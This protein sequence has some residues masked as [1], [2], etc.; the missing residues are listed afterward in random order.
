[1]YLV[2]ILL[3]HYR[4]DVWPL[5]HVAPSFAP[6]RGMQTQQVLDPRETNGIR[7]ETNTQ[8]LELQYG[9]GF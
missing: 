1:T 9:T 6:G 3:K 2:E 8:I 7:T 4:Q 5:E